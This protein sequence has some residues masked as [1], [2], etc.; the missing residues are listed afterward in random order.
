MAGYKA[1]SGRPKPPNI[2]R[3]F[4]GDEIKPTLYVTET[5]R[6]ILAGS[7]NG[8]LVTDEKGNVLPL[9]SVKHNGII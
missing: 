3:A 6:K 9:R 2:K 4:N 1:S 7:I 8:E 5:G